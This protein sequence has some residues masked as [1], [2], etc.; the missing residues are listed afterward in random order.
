MFQYEK[1]TKIILTI[2][3]ITVVFW[4]GGSLIRN[5]MAFDLFIPATELSLKNYYSEEVRMH[6]IHLYSVS[7]V[8]TGISFGIALVASVLLFIILLKKLKY[9]GWLFMSFILFFIVAIVELYITYLDVMLGMAI[10]DSI[11]YSFTSD[12][13]KDYFLFRYYKLG[14]LEPMK[15]LGVITI[16]I[17]AVWKPLVKN[18][19]NYVKQISDE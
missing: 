8:Y 13:I 7:S 14:I 6:T 17:L 11:V 18:P 16:I 15:Y 9:E 5:I 4:I 10:S 1:L 12:P 3:I 2:F 19:S